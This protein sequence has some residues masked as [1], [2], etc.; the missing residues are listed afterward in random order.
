MG[1]LGQR[2]AGS[3]LREFGFSHLTALL[4]TRASFQFLKSSRIFLFVFLSWAGASA[5]AQFCL[6]SFNGYGPVY[7]PATQERTELFMREIVQ[8]GCQV[9]H[10]QEIWN[11]GQMDQVTRWAG[12]SYR[13]FTPNRLAKN[14]LMS[15]SRWHIRKTQYIRFQFNTDGGWLDGGREIFGVEKGFAVQWLETPVGE[16]AFVN[17]HLHPSSKAVRI[18]QLLEVIRWRMKIGAVPVVVA[19]DFNMA[20]RSVERALVIYGL[21]VRDAVDL[22]WGGYPGGFCTYCAANPLGWL[23]EDRIFDYAFF[24]GP[25][26]IRDI[27]I[28]LKDSAGRVLSDH[29]GLRVDWDFDSRGIPERDL[30]LESTRLLQTFELAA[31]PLRET[32][33]AQSE[34]LRLLVG[35]RKDLIGREGDFWA[36]FEEGL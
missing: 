19:G 21:K 2:V 18:A 16:I 23:S 35:Y 5:H 25:F 26:R 13:M 11:S 6:Q 7:A 9:V 24:S 36:Y 15:L 22:L 29:Y 3:R 30:A 17:L 8:D 4:K 28:N 20:P 10:L 33:G 34:V 12:P 32:Y 1:I 31:R 14:G 27:K